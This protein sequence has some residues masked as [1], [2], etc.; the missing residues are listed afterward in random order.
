MRPRYILGWDA[1]GVGELAGVADGVVIS[2]RA[3]GGAALVIGGIDGVQGEAGVGLEG[4][5]AFSEAV[6]DGGQG[7]LLPF[8]LVV[9][10]VGIL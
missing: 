8:L 1:A 3:V 10:I 6:G 4:G 2:R 5:A 7:V 9:D